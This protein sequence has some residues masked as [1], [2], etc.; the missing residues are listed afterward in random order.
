MLKIRRFLK[1]EKC[2]KCK[3]EFISISMYKV[4]DKESICARCS[5]GECY[6]TR[7]VTKIG[8]ETEMSISFEFETNKKE[9]ELFELTKYGFIGC[10]D[11]SI[12]GYE[13]KSRAKRS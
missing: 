3:N 10:I 11:G 8:K 12:R 1:Y 2:I 7:N 4:N 13:W 6:T 9:I 5:Y